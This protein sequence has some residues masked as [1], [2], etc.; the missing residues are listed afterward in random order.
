MIVDLANRV[1][2]AHARETMDDV[3]RQLRAQTGLDIVKVRPMPR[4]MMYRLANDATWRPVA[5]L[6]AGR[7]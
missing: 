3:C 1:V 6:L 4:G 7:R 2:R 5:E